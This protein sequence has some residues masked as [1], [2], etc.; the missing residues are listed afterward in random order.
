MSREVVVKFAP[1]VSVERLGNP[2]WERAGR[3]MYW[4][5]ALKFLPTQTEIP[6]VVDH[7]MDR[8][9]GVVH[10]LFQLDWTDGGPWICARATVTDPPIWLKRHE[11]KASFGRWDIHSTPVGGSLRVTSAWM[12]EVSV[13]HPQSN[14]ANLSPACCPSGRPRSG[15]LEPPGAG[16]SPGR[17]GD[18]HP[19]RCGHPA[20]GGRTHHRG[21]L[22]GTLRRGRP[23]PAGW[24]AGVHQ[25]SSPASLEPTGRS[26][27]RASRTTAACSPARNPPSRSDHYGGS[28]GRSVAHIPFAAGVQTHL[29]PRPHP[30]C[31]GPIRPETSSEPDYGGDPWRP[32]RNPPWSGA[33]RC[34]HGSLPRQHFPPATIFKRSRSGEPVV[35]LDGRGRVRRAASSGSTLGDRFFGQ[36]TRGDPR[37]HKSLSTSESAATVAFN[38]RPRLRRGASVQPAADRSNCESGSMPV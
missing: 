36:A 15:S 38:T 12:R 13:L 29:R 28:G 9:V 27:R 20:T 30:A 6:L 19:A 16:T 3:T 4:P 7:N 33:C 37:R 10:E 26:G 17:R 8:Q 2:I 35:D 18:P 14:P 1:I 34:G 25:V 23:T 21:A 22:M 5:G 31:A 32:A 11:T 24:I